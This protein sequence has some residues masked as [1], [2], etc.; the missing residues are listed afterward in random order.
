MDGYRNLRKGM[1]GGGGMGEMLTTLTS[2][3]QVSPFPF[4][5]LLLL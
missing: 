2:E 5:F 3:H 1:G 4:A